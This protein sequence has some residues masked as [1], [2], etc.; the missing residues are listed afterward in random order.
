[1]LDSYLL[2]T[3]KL[4]AQL[5]RYQSPDEYPFFPDAVKDIKPILKPLDYPK[6]LYP[7]D[8]N[9]NDKL[10]QSYID[11][12]LPKA[13]AH[14]GDR[15]ESKEN[16]GSAA[17]VDVLCLQALSRRIHYGKFVAEVKFQQE[18][19]AI[20]ELIRNRDR[21]GINRIITDEA[22]ERQVL[23]RLRNKALSYGRDPTKPDA[24]SRINADAVVEMYRVSYCEA[25]MVKSTDLTDHTR[26]RTT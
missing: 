8:V 15:G 10:K 2:Q 4:Q 16:Y 5:R 17:T 7:N 22:V 19:A 25:D 9:V 3:E 6:V 20:T 23:E 21:D 26:C 1:M 11:T 13:C 24:P 12:I 18:T 14:G